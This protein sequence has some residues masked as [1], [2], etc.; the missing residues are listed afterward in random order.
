MRVNKPLKRGS[1][2]KTVNSKKKPSPPFRAQTGKMR[3]EIKLNE[4]KV[5][6]N[7]DEGKYQ[8]GI[9]IVGAGWNS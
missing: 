8:T 5:A 6:T 9:R 4:I 7:W 2:V 1:S 3:N